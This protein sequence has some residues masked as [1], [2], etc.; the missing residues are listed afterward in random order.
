MAFSWREGKQNTRDGRKFTKIDPYVK[1]RGFSKEE[2]DDLEDYE[3][4]DENEYNQTP[5][6][7][8]Q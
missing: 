6:G 1:K 4:E 3:N 5:K 7:T 2:L 8:K